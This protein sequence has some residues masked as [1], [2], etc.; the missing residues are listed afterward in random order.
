MGPES[1]RIVSL[2]AGPGKPLA[3]RWLVQ[4][5]PRPNPLSLT[6]CCFLFW[7]TLSYF[8]CFFAPAWLML[9]YVIASYSLKG[10]AEASPP[11]EILLRPLA[12]RVGLGD[13]LGT[14]ASSSPSWCVLTVTYW[15]RALFGHRVLSVQAVSLLA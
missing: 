12:P 13:F 7:N 5:F 4:R 9:T 10:L 6:L 3:S 15:V 11:L 14:C 2:P 1:S 8:V